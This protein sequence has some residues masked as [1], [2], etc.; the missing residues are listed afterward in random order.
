[1]ISSRN[2]WE[3]CIWSWSPYL[4]NKEKFK[5]KNWISNIFFG[6]VIVIVHFLFLE[7]NSRVK[8]IR[9]NSFTLM[10]IVNM[11]FRNMQ[12]VKINYFHSICFSQILS[13]FEVRLPTSN[14]MFSVISRWNYKVFVLIRKLFSCSFKKWS[15]FLW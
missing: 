6:A 3:N 9:W 11:I 8:G 12:G 4:K 15:C 10:I 14:V 13:N 5:R 2:D 1:M 7:Y